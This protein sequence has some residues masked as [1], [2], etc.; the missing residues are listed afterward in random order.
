MRVV[1][2]NRFPHY[3]NGGV[4]KLVYVNEEVCIG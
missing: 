1:D 2:G 4:M 3:I